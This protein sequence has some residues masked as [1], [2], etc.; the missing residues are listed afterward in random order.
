MSNKVKIVTDST[1][2]LPPELAK[3]LGISVVPI[4]VRFGNET[5]RDIIEISHDE[6][7]SRLANDS[8]HPSTSQPPPSDFAEVYRQLSQEADEIVSI[9]VSSKL[10]G[11]YQS[12]LNAANTFKE[13]H[14]QVVDSMA[15]S[16][17]LGLTV[18][19]AARLAQAGHNISTIMEEVK[20]AVSQT[21]M[22]GLLDSLKYLA[23]GGR[24]GKAK[25]LLGGI[26]NVKPLL[27]LKDGE[28][29]PSGLARTRGK[30]L[31]RFV[32]N[33]KGALGVQEAA[34]VYSTSHE[35]AHSLK[36]RIGSFF[37]KS[38]I[39]ISQLGPAL[40]AHGGPGTLLMA[41]REK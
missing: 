18:I 25:S 14:V 9:H 11:T 3:E 19:T 35:E 40:G 7:Y 8:T 29:H 34:I 36:E 39:H 23:R 12:A 21:K 26:L 20:Q 32:D 1:A 2:D 4:Y 16:M 37:D 10:S 24:V 31:E 27:F 22:M 6:L 28:I 15:V 33:I 17:G 5:Y 41:F 30:G 13:S 38:R